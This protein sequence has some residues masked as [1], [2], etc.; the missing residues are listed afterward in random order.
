MPVSFP[1]EQFTKDIQ[2]DITEPMNKFR[3]IAAMYGFV[4]VV[5]GA[6]GAHSLKPLL[7]ENDHLGAWETA[8]LYLFVHV[9]AILILP[10]VESKET[11]ISL[12]I[13]GWSWI[14]GVFLFSGS[15]YVL[16]LTDISKL[17][18]ITP[19]GG[20]GFLV[21]WGALIYSIIQTNRSGS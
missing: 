1:N 6:F 7:V 20:V 17:G 4:G 12:K 21:G 11:S 9:L 5:L 8:T 14:F 13:I 19:I 15:L 2:S 3:L 18:M 10:S 16:A